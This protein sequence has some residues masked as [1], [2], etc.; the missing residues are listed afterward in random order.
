MAEIRLQINLDRGNLLTKAFVKVYR[1][2]NI[3]T[4]K[5][6]KFS[7]MIANTQSKAAEGVVIPKRKGIF[8]RDL[9]PSFSD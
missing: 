8:G 2:R 5:R 3:I 7:S 1:G 9:S 4:E 6:Y